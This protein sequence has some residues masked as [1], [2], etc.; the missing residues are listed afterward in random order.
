M[1]G[2]MDLTS[3]GQAYSDFKRDKSGLQKPR[4]NLG[5]SGDV[6]YSSKQDYKPHSHTDRTASS[7]PR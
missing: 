5:I 7:K 2:D 4:D 1:S 3:S 6:D